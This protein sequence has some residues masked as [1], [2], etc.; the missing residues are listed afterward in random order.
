MPGR[1]SLKKNR[2]RIK[3]N[4]LQKQTE[5]LPAR[6]STDPEILKARMLI[7]L[8][9]RF[10]RNTAKILA[11]VEN[12]FSIPGVA[13]SA[14]YALPYKSKNKTVYVK[15]LSIVAAKE[16]ARLYKHL[17]FGF[18]VLE[19]TKTHARAIAYCLDLQNNTS[20]QRA[21]NM[22]IPP[23][24]NKKTG[25]LF[26][27]S[28]SEIYR[29]V[30]AEGVKRMRAC[31]L[32]C[33]PQALTAAAEARISKT[34]AEG[35]AKKPSLKGEFEKL[36]KKF[37]AKN[38]GLSAGWVLNYLNKKSVEELVPQDLVTLQGILNAFEDGFENGA[39]AERA[40]EPPAE[41]S[42]DSLVGSGVEETKNFYKT[43]P[44]RNKP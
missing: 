2:G 8:D 4:D 31:I 11:G 32:H 10:E 6:I 15:G 14:I 38:E 42:A 12:C 41:R 28:D 23:K 16:A 19:Q 43:F 33:L 36:L 24:K 7:A 34:L 30:S 1:H 3:M 17:I 21:V 39:P 29:I 44:G 26:P 35:V 37:Q 9:E 25:E 5:S 22:K 40:P 20:E 27:P 13:K 18:D